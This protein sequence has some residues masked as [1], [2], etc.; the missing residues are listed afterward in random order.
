MSEP[1]S[2]EEYVAQRVRDWAE[3]PRDWSHLGKMPALRDPDQVIIRASD[4]YPTIDDDTVELSADHESEVMSRMPGIRSFSDKENGMQFNL[5]ADGGVTG[6]PVEGR[7]ERATI[8][9]GAKQQD[10]IRSVFP[11]IPATRVLGH[12]HNAGDPGGAYPGPL[13]YLVVQERRIPNVI[14]HGATIMALEKVGGRMQARVLNAE[15]L[16]REDRKRIQLQMDYFQREI[17]RKYPR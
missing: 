12:S 9:F 17:A 7:S 11:T 6:Y 10:I 3:Q 4:A 13:D 14:V 2:L 8:G 5:N 15:G 1:V 16:S